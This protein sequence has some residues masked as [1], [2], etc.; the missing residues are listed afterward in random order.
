MKFKL[1]N[2]PI[3]IEGTNLKGSSDTT[4]TH[5]DLKR[6]LRDLKDKL[7]RNSVSKS[8]GCEGVYIDNS[9]NIVGWNEY[10]TS[11]SF[12]HEDIL[13]E[14]TSEEKLLNEACNTLI[15]KLESLSE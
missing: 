3:K 7:L 13:R 6:L 10:Y 2:V 11:H 8:K 1:T 5:H 4:I 14:A 9:G 15:S 12:T